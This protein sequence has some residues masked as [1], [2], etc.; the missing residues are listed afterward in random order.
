M[1]LTETAVVFLKFWGK[2]CKGVLS[3]NLV[4][5]GFGG[6]CRSLQ[7]SILFSPRRSYHLRIT[8][9][10]HPD[11]DW[12]GRKKPVLLKHPCETASI[13]LEEKHPPLTPCQTG[14]PLLWRGFLWNTTQLTPGV[15][16]SFRLW[17]FSI[18]SW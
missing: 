16:V 6:S 3:F 17:T 7:S 4:L 5:C 2:N 14:R 12:R 9:D 15:S 10:T 1:E 18:S 8:S 13:M 11:K